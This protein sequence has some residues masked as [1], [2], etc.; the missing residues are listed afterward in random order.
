MTTGRKQKELLAAALREQGLREKKAR[1]RERG[2][3]LHFVRDLWGV[4]EPGRPFVEGWAV[5]ALCRHLEAITRKEIGPRILANVPPGFM[6]SMLVNVFWPAWE[7]GP[8]DMAHLRYVSFSY[9]AHL[10]ERDNRRF[11]MLLQSQE[12]KELYTHVQLVKAGEVLVSNTKHGWKLATSVGGVGTGERG[13][14]ILLDDPHNVAEAESDK[15]RT[16]TVSWFREAMSNRLNDLETGVIVIIMQRVHEDDVSGNILDSELPYLHLCVPME[17]EEDRHCSTP[18]WEDPRT[19]DGELAWPERFPAKTLAEFKANPFLWSGQYQQSPAPRGGGMFRRD[20]WVAWDS[21]YYPKFSLVVASLDSSFT[22]RES[23]DPNGFTV[24]GLYHN[25][26]TGKPQ[27]ML[28][29]AWRKHLEMHGPRV[30][31]EVW[32]TTPQYEARTQATWGLVEW[33]AYSCRK[34]KV[35]KLLVENKASGLSVAQEL[36]RLYSNEGWGVELVTPIGDKEARGHAVVH[37][38]AE[39]LVVAPTTVDDQGMKMWR[40]WAELVINEMAVF[41]RGKRKDLTDS[42]TQALQWLRRNNLMKTIEED[43]REKDEEVVY[44]KPEEA[45]YEV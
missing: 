43:K 44:R 24:W 41:P 27:V 19:V 2:G 7:W 12:F 37:L 4:L 8:M 45:L 25:E 17:Y 28:V 36:V 22:K 18:I 31:R 35:E 20:Y 11:L 15:V 30:E 13:D 42:A 34:F 14:R 40:P 21:K 26:K 23:N 32:E 39:G 3:L 33:V 10:T 6:K 1:H 38:F 16:S 9:A 29:T 5:E